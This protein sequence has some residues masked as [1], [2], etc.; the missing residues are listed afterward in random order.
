MNLK[1]ITLFVGGVILT[2]HLMAAGE[3]DQSITPVVDKKTHTNERLQKM[4]E[5]HHFNVISDDYSSGGM[6]YTPYEK[7]PHETTKGK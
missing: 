3:K 4:E 7:I 5:I 6:P 2:T 1:F